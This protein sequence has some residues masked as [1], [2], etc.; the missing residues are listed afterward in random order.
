MEQVAD[1]LH[2]C[3]PV[4]GLGNSNKCCFDTA[5]ATHTGSGEEVVRFQNFSLP[6]ATQN[7]IKRGLNQYPGHRSGPN[8]S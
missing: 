4:M 1:T 3:L 5:A 2:N 8:W 7:K 6:S